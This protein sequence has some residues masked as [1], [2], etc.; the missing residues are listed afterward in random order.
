VKEVSLQNRGPKP[1]RIL[2][3]Q[4]PSTNITTELTTVREGEEYRLAVQLREASAAGRIQGEVRVHTD[5][6]EE[7]VLTVPLYGVVTDSQ[8]AGR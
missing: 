7:K 4:P 1:V 8:R 5:H 3:V 6:P 2:R